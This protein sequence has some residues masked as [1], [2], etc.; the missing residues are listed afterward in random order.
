MFNRPFRA[1]ASAHR[2]RVVT[3]IAAASVVAACAA[4]PPQPAPPAL[5]SNGS[6]AQASTTLTNPAVPL[7]V[8]NVFTPTG[9]G[10]TPF[11]GGTCGDSD[12]PVV[13]VVHGWLAGGA[14]VY[15]GLIDHL[16]SQGNIVV[17]GT[18]GNDIA[19]VT[20]S[21]DNADAQ[22]SYAGPRLGARADLGR[23]GVIGHSL[24]GG[25]VPLL[26]QRIVTR[27]WG[28]TGLWLMPLAPYQT[29]P[30]GSAP[31]ALPAHARA[32]VEAY[33]NDTLVDN[34]VGITMFH[35][36]SMP[37][38]Q[39]QHVT[40][41]SSSNGTSQ[42]NATHTSPNSVIAPD[43]AIKFF[44]IYRVVDALESCALLNQS[45]NADLSLMGNWSDGSP[46]LPSASTDSPTAL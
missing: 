12:R 36:L 28:S 6:C 1:R 43:D 33:D 30:S 37:Y 20:G 44:G 31:I 5:G 10:S 42:L 32:V 17:F 27:G 7:N 13:F 14:W 22:I 23:V 46:V 29:L 25:I 41:R 2:R 18:Y 19:N 16:V 26:T 40:V 24:G 8:I 45:C 9:S 39:K 34:Q 3:A 11:T 38:S 35:R 4:P 21:A 15:Q